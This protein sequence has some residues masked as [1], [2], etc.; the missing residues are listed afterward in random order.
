MILDHFW[1]KISH[2]RPLLPN[3]GPSKVCKLRENKSRI[4]DYRGKA[5]FIMQ[6]C[7]FEPHTKYH[8]LPWI[9]EFLPKF[10]QGTVILPTYHRELVIVKDFFKTKQ[11]MLRETTKILWPGISNKY[12]VSELVTFRR[13]G[14]VHYTTVDTRLQ[15]GAVGW[16]DPSISW[17]IPLKRETLRKEV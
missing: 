12:L 2:L 10:N 14:S 5:H 16:L 17:Q 6:H 9:S 1:Q 11:W 7:P 15:Y 3:N 8:I 13:S 4:I